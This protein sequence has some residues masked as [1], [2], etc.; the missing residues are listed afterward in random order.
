MLQGA[1]GVALPVPYAQ[2]INVSVVQ[3]KVTFTTF[4]GKVRR[5][6][7]ASEVPVE[8]MAYWM[9]Q[10][11]PRVTAQWQYT[12]VPERA[13]DEM[14]IANDEP[15]LIIGPYKPNMTAA[16]WP[17]VMNSRGIIG[18]VPGNRLFAFTGTTS[19]VA[20]FASGPVCPRFI[21]AGA[22]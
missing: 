3:A 15:L 6:M 18:R 20:A 10:P 9:Q 4:D 14:P 21:P 2:V 22:G 17:M 5:T 12:P 13:Y 1:S 16:N 8:T 7:P 11:L 19:T